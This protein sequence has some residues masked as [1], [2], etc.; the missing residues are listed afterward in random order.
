MKIGILTFHRAHNYGALL[1]AY[2][3]T[4]YLQKLGHNVEIIDYW[5]NY[6]QE[7]YKLIPFYNSISLKGKIKSILLLL[8]G[9]TRILK[10]RKLYDQFIAT[11]LNIDN[12]PKY[13][14]E[15]EL[16]KLEYD[17]VIYGSDQIWRKSNYYIFKGYNA[18]YFG[19]SPLKVKFKIPY[20]ASM[21]VINL[22]EN[23]KQFI[24]KMMNNFKSISV[25]EMDLKLII[26]EFTE[27]K[28]KLVLD[29]VFLLDKNEWIK[30]TKKPKKI[31]S[32]K[33]ILFYNLIKTK[34]AIELT[35][36]LQ[37]HYGYKIIEIR[38]RV[39]PLLLSSRYF[40]TASPE[41]FLSL[42]Q[43]AEIVVST[44]FH[45]VAFSIIFEKQFYTI[46][47]N[48]NSGRVKTL[49]DSAGIT[50]RFISKINQINYTEKIDYTSVNSRLKILINESKEFL[51]Q[52]ID[53]N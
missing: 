9:I 7:E 5:P 25:R 32:E 6:L 40:Q 53:N 20:A 31:N 39:E 1:Q 35:N 3:L 41:N 2:A 27:N 30:L 17:A 14:T 21:G 29:P 23:D 43:N 36:Q 47:M 51:N 52:A 48:N 26:D 28:A 33:Y 44:S 42:I 22:I 11:Y 38:G 4:N 24:K 45:G 10:R 16:N 18:V 19:A 46:G 8:I 13:K 34:E 50:G 12:N 15:E 37:A 49:L